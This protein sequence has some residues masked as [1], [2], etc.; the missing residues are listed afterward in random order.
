MTRIVLA[1]IAITLIAGHTLGAQEPPLLNQSLDVS[2]DFLR[3]EDEFFLANRLVEFDSGS[4]TGWLEWQRHV[5]ATSMAFNKVALTLKKSTG[6]EFPQGEYEVDPTLPFS[7]SFISPRTVRIRMSTRREY[8]REEPSLMLVGEPPEDTSWKV[9]RTDSV[10]TYRSSHGSVT[11]QF[12]PW[13][14]EFRDADNRLLTRTEHTSDSRSLEN[15]NPWPFLFQRRSADYRR[16]IVPVFSLFPDEKIFGGGESFTRLD[17]RGQKLVL[18]TTDAMSAATGAMYKP[19]PFF[20]S[21]RGYGMF[22]HASTPMAF[23]FGH[24]NDGVT[25]LFTGDDQLDLFVFLGDP[26]EIL[27]EYT[28]LTG[29]SPLPPL[30]SFGLWMS[31]ITYASEA[32]AREVAAKLRQHEIP[33]DVIHLD[34]GWFETDWRCDYRFAPSRFDDP[35]GMIRDLKADGFRISL[36]QLPYFVAG[37]ALFDEIVNRDLAVLDGEGNLPTDDAMLDFSKRETVVW[38][39]QHIARLMKM[40]VGAIKVDFGEALPIKGLFASGKSGY[41]EH[42]LYPLRY[43]RAV[44]DICS[45]VTGES[46][47]WARSAWAGS[48]RYPV[49]WGGDAENTDYAMAASLRAGLSLGLSGFSFWSHDIGGFVKPPHEELYRRWMPFGMLTS[50]SRCH[51]APPKEPWAFS[52]SFL[53]TFR[54]TVELKYRLMPYVYAQ[55]AMSSKQGFPM[56][57]TLF[58]EYP[59]DPT[60]WFIEDEYLFGTDILVAP[61]F[62][63]SSDRRKVYLPPGTWIDYQKGD[64]YPGAEWHSIAAGPLPVIMLVK[65]GAVIPL[66]GIAQSTDRIDWS[67]IELRVFMAET[68]TA[69]GAFCLP[70]DNEVVSLKVEA[71]EGQLILPRDP[72]KGRVSWNI[73]SHSRP[74]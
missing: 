18:W 2:K 43:N 5:L 54:E 19:I 14:L 28:A 36:W 16:Q 8:R 15:T 20:M 40:G 35:A 21:S 50:H 12:E 30:W 39:Q 27:S 42:N 33:S 25:K 70:E 11:I 53:E 67:N 6:R 57:R 65:E 52:D 10:A 71:V 24:S 37:N 34:T 68:A 22:V 51:G 63:E 31:R 69:E 38:Y 46:I 61:L 29:R 1:A 72:L 32:E 62:E 13:H 60:S 23:D 47:I 17:K 44:A 55:A 9:E 64:V 66:A 7:M 26:K 73:V 49:H 41:Y 48:Q 45:E 74:R 59:D 56:L 58:F 4:A 3:M